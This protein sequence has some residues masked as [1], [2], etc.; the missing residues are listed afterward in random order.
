MSRFPIKYDGP[1]YCLQCQAVTQHRCTVY[2]EEDFRICT[3]CD[4]WTRWIPDPD[5]TKESKASRGMILKETRVPDKTKDSDDFKRRA[6]RRYK[7][8]GG[9]GEE[10]D[11]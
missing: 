1:Y 6:D 3:R 7:K 5:W 8:R 2:P 4:T 10:E 11:E 9:E